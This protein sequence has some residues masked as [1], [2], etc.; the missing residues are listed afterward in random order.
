MSSR[1]DRGQAR[2]VALRRPGFRL[3]HRHLI[4]RITWALMVI[5]AWGSCRG[6]WK[7]G[8]VGVAASAV[9][10]S[11]RCVGPVKL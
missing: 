4:S 6:P 3:A 1:G 7:G 11:R 5:A 9:A 10:G 2:H 8:G